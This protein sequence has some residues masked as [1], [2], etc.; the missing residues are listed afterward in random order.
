M[1]KYPTT[2]TPTKGKAIKRTTE[3]IFVGPQTSTTCTTI[4]KSFAVRVHEIGTQFHVEEV[5][6]TLYLKVCKKSKRRTFM[7]KKAVTH[8]HVK[9]C[10]MQKLSVVEI[11]WCHTSINRTLEHGGV[12]VVPRLG[13]GVLRR[14]EDD[15]GE[16]LMDA[17]HEAVPPKDGG[18]GVKYAMNVWIAKKKIKENLDV[19]AYR[20]K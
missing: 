20:T 10:K 1:A 11:P 15:R 3:S 17:V 9:E 7:E 12:A 4:K 2:R 18:D 13:D 14:N 6:T 19:S 8:F 16:L 5:V